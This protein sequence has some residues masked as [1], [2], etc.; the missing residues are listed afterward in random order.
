MR[1]IQAVVFAVIIMGLC[2]GTLAHAAEGAK[3]PTK[4]Q[5]IFAMMKAMNVMATIDAMMP[6]MTTGMVQAM[7]QNGTEVS[8]G[9]EEA[10]GNATSKVM[11]ANIRPFL[12]AMVGLYDRNYSAQEIDDLVAFYQSP[13]GK[14]SLQIMPQ[15]ATQSSSI[16]VK[17]AQSLRP[18]LEAE[19]DKVLAA[20]QGG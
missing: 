14:K 19:L 13:T 2:G 4:Q 7:R 10:I 12:K 20:K 15:L 17:W 11:R 18:H 5:K 1:H 3:A 9:L 8:P 16:A 6:Q